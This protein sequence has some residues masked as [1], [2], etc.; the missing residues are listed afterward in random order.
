MDKK[1]K[2]SFYRWV[3]VFSGMLL[4]ALGLGMYYSTN[5]VFIKPICDALGFTR[6]QFTLHRTIITLIGTFTMPLYGRLLTKIGPKRILFAGALGLCSTSFG[7]SFATQL[8]HF[9]LTALI[10]GLF[11]NAVN[12]ITVGVLVNCWFT[13]KIGLATGIA[14][15]G[16]SLGGAVMIPLIGSVIETTNWQCAYRLMGIIG[17]T[18]MVPVILLMVKDRPRM[19][20]FFSPAASENVKEANPRTSPEYTYQQVL[21]DKKFWLL[22]IAFF[23][24]NFFA[25]ATNTHTAPYLSDLGYPV[26]LVSSMVSLLMVFLTIGK[27]LL[28]AV[29]DRF[30]T[31]MGNLVVIIS[32]T[33]F[34]IFALLSRIQLF[35]WSY[36]VFVGIASCGVSVPVT[37]L[38]TLYYGEKNFATIFS[39]CS[40]ISSLAPS[41]SIPG[42]GLVYDKT[43]N[44]HLAWVIFFCSAIIIA[45]CLFSAERILRKQLASEQ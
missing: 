20:V 6:G 10:N 17:I 12:F 43:N 14:F 22:V 33:L 38:L 42:M 40:M 19:N 24:I 32:C 27:V 44:Y 4:L 8:W 26:T 31:T 28:G 16:S 9:Y 13:D 37:I 36:V 7:Y 11:Y 2:D 15:S 34:P 35:A 29:Y 41:L 1:K 45:I 3:I 18:I 39:L 21:R 23:F 25:G 5:S 30:G